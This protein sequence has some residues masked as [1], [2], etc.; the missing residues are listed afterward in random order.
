MP[1]GASASGGRCV[2]LVAQSRSRGPVGSASSINQNL[3][4]VMSTTVV[5]ADSSAPDVGPV[6]AIDVADPSADEVSGSVTALS[7]PEVSVVAVPAPP[8]PDARISTSAAVNDRIITPPVSD[9]ENRRA[10]A[11]LLLIPRGGIGAIRG[12]RHG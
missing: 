9:A 10:R 12:R 4:S 11:L 6:V 5:E 8:H 1:S 2:V 7:D 3:A